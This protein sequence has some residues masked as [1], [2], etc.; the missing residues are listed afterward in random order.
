MGSLIDL[1]GQVFGKLTVISRAENSKNKKVRYRCQCACGNETIVLANSLLTNRT[2]SC[3]CLRSEREGTQKK[4]I[5]K[6]TAKNRLYRIW[7]N[8][9]SRCENTKVNSFPYYGGRGVKVCPEWSV[10]GGFDRFQEWAVSHGYTDDLEIDRIN[11]NGNYEPNNCRWVTTSVNQSNKRPRG[12]SGVTGVY[13]NRKVGK[14]A[15]QITFNGNSKHLG[16]FDNK[17]DAIAA[18]KKAEAEYW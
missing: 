11:V 8:M 6:H 4:L 2:R 5:Q 9:H 18:R 13:F 14:W 16:Y 12:K 17:E 1:T 3:G 7:V 15:A 10:P